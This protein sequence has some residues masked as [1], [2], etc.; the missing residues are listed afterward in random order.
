M[1][2]IIENDLIQALS[3]LSHGHKLLY[4]ILWE[5][6]DELGV[7]EYDIGMISDAA[8]IKYHDNDF[9]SFGKRVVRFSDQQL[10]LPLYLSRHIRTFDPNNPGQKRIWRKLKERWGATKED[11]EP[12]YS[13]CRKADVL[14]LLPKFPDYHLDENGIKTWL[15]DYRKG[16]D[17]ALLVD[18]PYGWPEP[19]DSAFKSYMKARLARCMKITT[20]SEK[21]R[22]LL[23]P[24]NVLA[25]QKTVA[26]F[27][28]E[29]YSDFQITKAIIDSES[30]NWSVFKIYEKPA[31][32]KKH[33]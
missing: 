27:L 12:L 5:L 29:G 17:K 19:I 14:N 20:K 4:R 32:A 13:R 25:L 24:E 21:N 9:D 11:M 2:K 26:L 7:V 6:A 18:T 15:L 22:N 23:E 31:N 10:F 30:N 33:F 1:Q 8:G 16:L 28:Q 3:H